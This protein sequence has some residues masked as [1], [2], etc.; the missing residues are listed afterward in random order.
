MVSLESEAMRKGRILYLVAPLLLLVVAIIWAPASVLADPAGTVKGT[1]V[2]RTPG[3][4]GVGDASI[5]LVS[6]Q[7]DTEQ[8]RVETKSDALG[9]FEFTGIETSS[10]FDYALSVLYQEAEYMTDFKRFE[11]GSTTMDWEIPVYDATPSADNVRISRGHLIVD[12]QEGSLWVL[13]FFSFVNTGDRTFV[14]AHPITDDGRKETLRLSLP[15]GASQITAQEGLDECCAFRTDEGISDTLA[16]AP[17]GKNVVLSYSL[18]YNSP[19]V[20]LDLPLY[21][22]VDSFDLLVAEGKAKVSSSQLT[23]QQAV[24]MGGK[25]YQH[26]T[27]S[28][29]PAQ[30]ELSLDLT[31]I[32]GSSGV[33]SVLS[34]N[35]LRWGGIGAAGLGILVVLFFGLRDRK[36]A[37]ATAGAAGPRRP[38]SRDV[39]LR[40]LADLDDKFASGQIAE[41]KYERLREQKVQMLKEI[42]TREEGQA[43]NED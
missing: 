11:T 16:V 26:F 17:G 19:E 4:A 32:G 5:T 43:G 21:Y 41:D 20:Y 23:T 30:T 9:R 8:A 15:T 12:I 13:Q 24:D 40:E 33:S 27:A 34:P 3:G 25:K 1:L 7:G 38:A 31:E 42:K 37:V 39:L 14:G 36:P 22:P 2:N 10:D 28:K 6:Y 29:L 18:P 35:N